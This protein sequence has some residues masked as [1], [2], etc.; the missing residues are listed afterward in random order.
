MQMINV[1]PAHFVFTGGQLT[2]WL[3]LV[4]PLHHNNPN[5]G[6]ATPPFL[7]APACRRLFRQ[8]TPE[9]V[10]HGMDGHMHDPSW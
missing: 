5:S 7:E 9:G 10:A 4:T 3:H 1:L 2:V 8:C 6:L